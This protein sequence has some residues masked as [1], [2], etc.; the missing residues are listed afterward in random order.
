MCHFQIFS[1][2]KYSQNHTDYKQ[3]ATVGGGLTGAGGLA[4]RLRRKEQAGRAND[5]RA[6]RLLKY[7]QRKALNKMHQM[8]QKKGE[9]I[10]TIQANG[11][12]DLK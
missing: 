7:L 9:K 5:A 1:D 4:V 12:R 8:H 2:A 11:R 3:T 6:V 10:Q